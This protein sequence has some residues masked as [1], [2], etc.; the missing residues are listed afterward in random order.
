MK[1]E[2]QRIAIAELCGWTDFKPTQGPR[3]Y[4]ELL[5][6][7]SHHWTMLQPDKKW[8]G[9]PPDYLND[10]NAMAEAEAALIATSQQVRYYE[11]LYEVLSPSSAHKGRTG[12]GQVSF[13]LINAK[14]AKRAESFLKSLGKWT[15]D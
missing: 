4:D 8:R 2:K 9:V 5:E 6:G 11:V 7:A 12:F 15:D 1:P 3:T 10:L 13:Y 14:A